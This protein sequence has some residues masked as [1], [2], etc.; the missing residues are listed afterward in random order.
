MATRNN[1]RQEGHSDRS[2]KSA[3]EAAERNFANSAH[4]WRRRFAEAWGTF[5]LVLIAAGTAT[6]SSTDQVHLSHELAYA[7]P[8]PIVMV[9]IYFMGAVSGAH[10]NPAVTLAFAIR[11]NFP[12]IRVPG[13]IAAQLLGGAAAAAFLHLVLGFDSGLGATVPGPGMSNMQALLIEI[14]LTTG[15]VNTILG[16]ASGA[17]NVGTNAAIAV[18]G[19]IAVAGIW[20][21]S[22]SGAS[23]NLARSLAPDLLRGQFATS[24]IY[25]AGPLAGAMIAVGFEWVLKG[26]PTQAGTRAAQGDDRP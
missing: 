4:E 6:V 21:G 22:L 15:L 12:W 8:G 18:G 7:A 2:G 26:Q 16:T 14:V 19:Y 5:L 1:A 17:R 3:H 25:V 23:M 10:L 24:W 20:A 11:G 13:Y 9:V